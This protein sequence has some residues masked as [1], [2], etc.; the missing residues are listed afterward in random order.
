[1]EYKYKA[2]LNNNAT[3][4]FNAD[5]ATVNPVSIGETICH[6]NE[7]YRVF[8]VTHYRTVTEIECDK[9]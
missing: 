7:Y 3:T 2:T 9:M 8:T 6:K 5:I 4:S 1:M